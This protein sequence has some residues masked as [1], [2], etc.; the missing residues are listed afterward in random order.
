MK[1]YKVLTT[2]FLAGVLLSLSACEDYVQNVDDPINVIEAEA[3]ADEAQ[4]PFFMDGVVGRYHITHDALTV[5]AG[6]L[7]DALEFDSGNVRDATFPTFRD[8]DIGEITL[9]N[10]SVDGPFNNLGRARYLADDLLRVVNEI[11]FEDS[12]LQ[13]EATYTANLYG[14]LARYAYAAYFGLTEEQGGATIDNGP[15]IPSA[16]MY[17][18]AREKFQAAI[19]SAPTDYDERVANSLLGRT[20]LYEGDYASAIP[21]LEA[22]MEPGDAPFQSQHSLE[23][24]NA[25]D[26]QAGA[27]RNQLT[28]SSRYND[29]IEDDADEANRILL[30]VLPEDEVTDAGVDAGVVIYRQTKYGPDTNINIMSWQENHLMLAE[31]EIEEGGLTGGIT[32]RNL[33][34][35]VRDSHDID[36][37]GIGET[38]D[39]NLLLEER[40]KELYLTGNRMIDQRRF[41]FFHL[42]EGT[43]RYFPLTQS[44][45]NENPNID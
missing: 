25:F 16:D 3:I 19:T 13:T 24:Q 5:I 6:G 37:L 38:V 28:V 1:T 32:A 18:Q 27:S 4:I 41:D 40:D 15:F 12:D 26:S 30:E 45:R 43:W 44:E 22:G 29:Y 33:V 31:A 20:Y 34:N 10:N 8:I 36:P 23:S 7:S 2:V 14:G 17:D 9:D 11:S 42:P 35:E 39:R 21:F